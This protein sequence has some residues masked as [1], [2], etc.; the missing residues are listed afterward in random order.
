MS[1]NLVYEF[2]SLDKCKESMNSIIRSAS[3]IRLSINR[4]TD[5]VY[6]VWQG[7]AKDAYEGRANQILAKLDIL[8][9]TITKD[10]ENLEKAEAIHQ[11]NEGSLTSSVNSLSA[12]DIF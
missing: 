10:K 7:K 1:V 4:I 12:D 2:D 5:N 8:I 11:S 6:G 3:D 9:E